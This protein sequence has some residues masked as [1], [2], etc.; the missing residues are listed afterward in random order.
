MNLDQGSP[1]LDM[2]G[3]YRSEFKLCR[4]P[5]PSGPSGVTPDLHSCRGVLIGCGVAM[6]LLACC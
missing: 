4:T 1:D 2:E 3:Q 5:S 6:R